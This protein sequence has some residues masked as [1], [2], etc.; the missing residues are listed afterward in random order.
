MLFALACAACSGPPAP[1]PLPLT[2][3]V[4]T[5]VEAPPLPPPAEPPR[6]HGSNPLLCKQLGLPCVFVE[7][8]TPSPEYKAVFGPGA[9]L[10]RPAIPLSLVVH[11]EGEQ[12]WSCRLEELMLHV[13]AARSKRVVNKA[14]PAPE[15]PVGCRIDKGETR[16]LTL[17]LGDFLTEV[18]A[19]YLTGDL[20]TIKA[21]LTLEP[22]EGARGLATLV[23]SRPVKV[24]I[25]VPEG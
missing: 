1:A 16:V 20:L 6:A 11:N 25:F 24:T 23:E 13:E 5:S 8:T 21:E 3:T 2:P 19:G 9:S 14:F 4:A 17:E 7:L 10:V 12:V 18:A 22:A 15:V